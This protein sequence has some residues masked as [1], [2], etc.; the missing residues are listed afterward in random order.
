[1][2]QIEFTIDS[3]NNEL[4]ENKELDTNLISDWYHTFGEL[5]EH[6][7]HL[8]ITLCSMITKLKCLR[9]D[10]IEHKKYKDYKIIKSK[11]H[12]DW[13]EYEWWFII[14]LETDNWQISYHL[15]NKYWDKCDFI[16]TVERANKW[17]WSTS[18]DVLDRLLLI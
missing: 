11:I 14:Q 13:S 18:T 16:K 10:Y 3:I 8:F 12:F 2:K 5:Y 4:R 1:M 15:P 7:I 17:D 6:R 9:N